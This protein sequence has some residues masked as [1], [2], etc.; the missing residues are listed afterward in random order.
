MGE[1]PA[2]P[3]F[4]MKPVFPFLLAAV[5]LPA[6]AL[7]QKEP[8]ADPF[9]AEAGAS[10]KIPPGPDFLTPVPAY[11]ADGYS[12]AVIESLIGKGNCAELWMICR[13]SFQPEYAV[14]LRHEIPVSAESWRD[15]AQETGW[16]IE[17]AI[18]HKKIWRYKD[19]EKGIPDIQVTGEVKRQRVEVTRE[20]AAAMMAAW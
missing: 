19:P 20:F 8:P 4:I 6:C 7:A 17:H 3:P 2:T 14:I 18:V 12:N 5:F 13:P 1:V 10:S 15:E 11:D 16:I 9:S